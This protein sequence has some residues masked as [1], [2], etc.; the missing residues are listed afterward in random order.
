M[1]SSS[2]PACHRYQGLA[3]F[4]QALLSVQQDRPGADHRVGRT[5]Q[6][7]TVAV[8]GSCSHGRRGASLL[9]GHGA[10]LCRCGCSSAWLLLAAC[11][12]CWLHV[13]PTQVWRPS[14]EQQSCFCADYHLS[15]TTATFLSC[16]L[17]PLAAA[18]DPAHACSF[19]ALHSLHADLPVM[20]PQEKQLVDKVLWVQALWRLRAS[21][22]LLIA[23]CSDSVLVSYCGSGWPHQDL[24]Q[25]LVLS[26][27]LVRN[28]MCRACWK[29][30]SCC[31]SRLTKFTTSKS[32]V[33]SCVI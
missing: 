10:L 15:S 19:A 23:V 9:W 22:C 1:T 27:E 29:F 3:P 8:R 14:C 31:D 32:H 17:P 28:K 4:S 24:L 5:T 20:G 11:P 16:R 2:S 25:S 7:L 18:S 13:H 33:H 6:S 30:S 12:S 26:P 21:F